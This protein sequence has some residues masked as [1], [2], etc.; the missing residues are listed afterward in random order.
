MTLF[1]LS[2]SL[3]RYP[4]HAIKTFIRFPNGALAR[5]LYRYYSRARHIVDDLQLFSILPFSS[6]DVLF[7]TLFLS[8]LLS[9]GSWSAGIELAAI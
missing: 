7:L 3:P 2:C 6:I 9:D 5:K 8:L 1:F 4:A